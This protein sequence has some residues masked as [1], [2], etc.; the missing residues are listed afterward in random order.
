MSLA[1]SYTLQYA[2]LFKYDEQDCTR[3][4]TPGPSIKVNYVAIAKTGGLDKNVVSTALNN[5]FALIGEI[6]SEFPLVEINLSM[7]G[8]L[9]G[10]ERKVTFHPRVQTRG[11]Y[12]LG[13]STV[14]N[15]MDIQSRPMKLAP[16]AG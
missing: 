1:D 9:Q 15:L 4:F 3:T 12:L 13:K 7:F 8:R 6:M 5:M 16:L 2:L 10:V 14:K 11:G